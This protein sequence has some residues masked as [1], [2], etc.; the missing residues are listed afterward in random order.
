MSLQIRFVVL[1]AYF[2]ITWDPS[3]KRA[4][5]GGSAVGRLQT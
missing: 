1:S 5:V 3:N 4:T 2:P